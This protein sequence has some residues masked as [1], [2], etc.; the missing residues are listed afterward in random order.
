MN[1][2]K[3]LNA[4]PFLIASY[5]VLALL[6]NNISQVESWVVFRPWLVVLAGT[7]LIF[8]LLRFLLKSWARSAVAASFILVLFFSYGQVYNLLKAGPVL[9]LAL[10][11]HRILGPLYLAA[12]VA[13]LW[14][15][16]FRLKQP[17]TLTQVLNL[18]GAALLILPVFTIASYSLHPKTVQ[19]PIASASSKAPAI[20]VPA[21][22]PKPDIY[23]IILDMYAR[24][25]ILQQQFGLDN[26]PFVDALQKMGF[27][28]PKC[29]RSNYGQTELSLSSSLNLNYLQNFGGDF[30]PKGSDRTY[31]PTLMVHSKVRSLLAGIGYKS[32]AFETGYSW[33]QWE[34]ADIYL[35]PTTHSLALQTFR[36]F[37]AML[38]KSTAGV[39]MTDGQT[40]L[41]KG[42]ATDVNFPYWDHINRTLYTLDELTS[43]PSMAGPKLV[44][45][46]ILV[47]HFPLVFNADGSIQTDPGYFSNADG[48]INDMFYKK[49][50]SAQVQF[51]NA[52]MLKIV[53]TILAQSKTPP[54]IIIQGDHGVYGIDRESNFEA[55]YLP[56][57]G[58]A[59]FYPTIS[60][61]N[62]FR[63]IF[64]TYFQGQYKP[65]P[66][67]SYEIDAKNPA[68]F[69]VNNVTPQCK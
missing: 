2:L 68:K 6:A 34:D 46:H 25:D 28:V 40:A 59:R 20:S 56:G 21:G 9:G 23:Y 7:A 55:Y 17:E 36:P 42:V 8:G 15:I 35:S 64:N 16:I 30:S 39:M 41:F 58:A 65:L 1:F 45:A 53:Q 32:V 61:V 5:A 29:S 49:G 43:L 18:V 66:D 63:V 38:F 60:P 33:D 10:G 11:R 27:Y 3:R 69:D 19:P 48:P 12:L 52:R 37:E 22:Q 51:I 4:H 44:F 57:D 54:I 24:S 62:S 47:P 67:I 13:G 14:A 50:Y 31:L 26:Q